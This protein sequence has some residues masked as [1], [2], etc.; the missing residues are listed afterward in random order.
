[1]G[2]ETNEGTTAVAEPAGVSQ[3]V[4]NQAIV[5]AEQ[6]VPQLA[7]KLPEKMQPQIDAMIKAQLRELGVVDEDGQVTRPPQA[8]ETSG[9]FASF[10]EQLQAIARSSGPG[11]ITDPRLGEIQAAVA[12]LSEG[13]PADGGFLLQDTF[14]DEI[15][16]L[17]HET[18]QVFNRITRR[19]TLSGN[20]ISLKM[21]AI[22]ESSRADGSRLGGVTAA[23][24]GEGQTIIASTP[25]FSRIALELNKLAALA[26]ATN[27]QLQD[28]P[29]IEQIINSAFASEMGFELDDAAIRGTGAG[30]PLGILNSPATV[31]VTKETGQAA[32]TVLFENITKMWARMWAQSR[33]NSVWFVNQDVEPQLQTMSLAVGTGGIPVYLP[34][35]GLSVA[36][37]ATLMG[38]PVVPIEQCAT[39][40]TV[41]DIILADM[42]QY[43]EINKG[44]VQNASSIHV[45]FSTDQTAFRATMREDYRPIWKTPLT[46]HAGS[47]LSPFV[48]LASRD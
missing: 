22:D 39:V 4:T 25:E 7:A 45:N 19:I 6:M 37:F 1:M 23:W 40:G 10:G 31:S 30:Q 44:G 20:S 5:M 42:S 38:R 12:G 16:R 9:P 26:H 24:L 18:G 27:E 13:V 43:W 8:D 3:E 33:G 28:T 46:P 14:S 34:A 2:D 11:A 36:P 41:G 15:W 35:G 17:M 32:D 47:T 48:T 29:V 21:P